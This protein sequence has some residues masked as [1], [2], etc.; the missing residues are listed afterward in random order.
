LLFLKDWDDGLDLPS[1]E[2]PAVDFQGIAGE[3]Q[4]RPAMTN[5]LIFFNNYFFLM[6]KRV[7]LPSNIS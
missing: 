4:R 1:H 7:N 5:L 2:K 6:Q 3:V